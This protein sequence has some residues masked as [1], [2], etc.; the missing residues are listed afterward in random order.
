MAERDHWSVTV[1]RNGEE[2]V[3]I[4]SNCLSGKSDLTDED[5]DVIRA[6]AEHLHSF[7]GPKRL[8]HC[9]ICGQ[10]DDGGQRCVMGGCP[11]GGDL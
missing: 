7:I 5:G 6:A 9:P 4:E 11:I 8:D 10:K 2:L 1:S 3:T